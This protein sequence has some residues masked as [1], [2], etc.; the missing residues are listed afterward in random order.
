LFRT[1][2]ASDLAACTVRFDQ[3]DDFEHISTRNSH[4]RPIWCG[5]DGIHR[6]A[7]VHGHHRR[8]IRRRRHFF[9]GVHLLLSIFVTDLTRAQVSIMI[10]I[11]CRCSHNR[12]R[13]AHRGAAAVNSAA[14]ILRLPTSSNYKLAK[15]CC[16]LWLL[17]L[18]IKSKRQ[19]HFNLS[20][21]IKGGTRMASRAGARTWQ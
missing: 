21:L 12:T 2:I 20:F 9:C 15:C 7:H 1:W 13:A 8:V 17:L 18:L 4:M 3:F 16:W 10:L 6:S 14:S 19:N 11:I 5:S